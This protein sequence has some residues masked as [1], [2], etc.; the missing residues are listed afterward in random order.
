MGPL[1]FK[2]SS[3]ELTIGD[4]ECPSRYVLAPEG[5]ASS[6]RLHPLICQYSMRQEK[7]VF[8]YNRMKIVGR[9]ITI[10]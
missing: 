8:A 9:T 6:S 5:M 4:F 3:L 2:A 1:A 7:V 10:T